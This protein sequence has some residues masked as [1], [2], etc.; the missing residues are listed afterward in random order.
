MFFFKKKS[1]KIFGEKLFIEVLNS[2]ETEEYS[3]E[4][5]ECHCGFHIGLDVTYLDQVGDIDIECP[6]C[7][8]M[9]S[10]T[11]HNFEKRD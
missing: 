3:L 5:I 11:A 1:E 10:V 7:R 6:S 2:V 9:I 4:V 8:K